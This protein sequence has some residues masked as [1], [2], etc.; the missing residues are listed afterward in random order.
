[1]PWRAKVAAVKY[2]RWRAVNG[3]FR[4]ARIGAFRRTVVIEGPEG[5]RKAVATRLIRLGDRIPA[6]GARGPW[7]N[8]A[9]GGELPE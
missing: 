3:T 1:V 4:R 7:D 6:K 2:A 9:I 5:L 8:W